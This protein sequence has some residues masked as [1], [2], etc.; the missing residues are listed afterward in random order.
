MGS[1]QST[2]PMAATDDGNDNRVATA[3]AGGGRPERG[4]RGTRLYYLVFGEPRIRYIGEGRGPLIFGVH[5]PATDRNLAVDAAETIRCPASVS[6]AT[7]TRVAAGLSIE[8]SVRSDLPVDIRIHVGGTIVLTNSGVEVRGRYAS[9]AVAAQRNA[10]GDFQGA[11][12]I[13]RKDIEKAVQVAQS[14]DDGPALADNTYDAAGQARATAAGVPL[15]NILCVELEYVGGEGGASI[16][17]VAEVSARDAFAGDGKLFCFLRVEGSLQ[18]PAA[19]SRADAAEN[20]EGEAPQ[21]P[22]LYVVCTLMQRGTQVFKVDT[23]FD[24]G[25]DISSPGG[26]RNE[27]DD[28]PANAANDS[29]DDD[30]G[31]C[32]VCL[33]KPK[34]T[35]ILPCR[36]MCMCSECA[37]AVRGQRGACP[38]C[39]GPIDKL[40]R[41]ATS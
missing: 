1:S 18:P 15:C 16:D 28:A 4:A 17:S 37:Q 26:P 27:G 5:T 10:S 41:R 39:R 11:A 19:A 2:G 20:D 14:D 6:S 32:V 8:C 9:Q 35:V 12:V 34:D 23:V 33:D 22:K 38:V 21:Q 7:A 36:H 40:M 30:G 29:G 13:G 31:D 24:A 25:R 3:A